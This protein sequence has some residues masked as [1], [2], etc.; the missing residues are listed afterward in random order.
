MG[1]AAPANRPK[2]LFP[3]G[4]ATDK[5]AIPHDDSHTA[6]TATLIDATNP[7]VLVDASTL[8]ASLQDLP[9][10]NPALTTAVESIRRHA[11]VLYGLAP[12]HDEAGRCRAVP[13]IALL[14]PP[15]RDADVRASAYSMGVP[16]PG[17]Q[18]T[19]TLCIATALTRPGTVASQ[20]SARAKNVAPP[21]STAHGEVIRSIE[22]PGGVAEA[23]V[24]NSK[25]GALESVGMVT[26]A[27]R[28]FKGEV[29]NAV[30]GGVGG[31]GGVRSS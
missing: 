2:R 19:G 21:E 17:L 9:P 6:V 18:L 7:F 30:G 28:L 1:T 27:R 22:H 24:R 8:P 29:V 15:T 4:T 12:N 31:G 26:T 13:K 14:H 16:H 25:S 20:I 11:S 23:V 5:I 10:G 3:T